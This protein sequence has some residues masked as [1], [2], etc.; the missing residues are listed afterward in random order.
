MTESPSKPRVL[1][2]DDEPLVLKGFQ[3]HLRKRFEV[4]TA[5]SGEEGLTVM[6][7]DGPFEVVVSDMRMPGMNG[8]EFLS[9][10]RQRWPDTVRILLT[11][12]ADTTSAI[13]AVNEGQIFRFL[14]K[15]CRPDELAAAV[16]DGV[17]EQRRVTADRSLLR[18]EA[19]RV[20]DRI[21]EVERQSR[22]GDLAG[23]AGHELAN[24]AAI[25][26]SMLDSTIA[27]AEH[28][29]YIS[30]DD[31]SE[32]R[33]IEDSLKRHAQ[34]LSDFA[35]ESDVES[36]MLDLRDAT[37][38]TL[39]TLQVLGALKHVDVSF[40]FPD[41]LPHVR[42]AGRR[43]RHAILNII[44]NA[45]DAVREASP[46]EPEIA[47]RIF[48]DVDE[49]R[50]TLEVEDNGTGVHP[51]TRPFVFKPY[52]STKKDHPGLGLAVASQIVTGHGGELT[53]DSHFGKGST[54][55]LALP[56]YSPSDETVRGRIEDEN[57]GILND[58][59][60]DDD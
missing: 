53:F 27:R 31:L 50:V 51:E 16:H 6:E 37:A 14:T 57:P 46:S 43:L 13:Q 24:L 36:S 5:E 10:A 7:R 12:Y 18:K 45:L 48:F 40:D 60:L 28:G 3:L 19:S 32:L 38:R 54:F 59:A 29:D 58:H 39:E 25:H 22:L 49:H 9:H 34:H 4:H 21:I 11:G 33:W 42:A 30:T 2:V 26:R 23:H 17:R 52:F 47:V 8:A 20:T 35:D 15:P 56:V 1:F 41:E 55:R 44:V